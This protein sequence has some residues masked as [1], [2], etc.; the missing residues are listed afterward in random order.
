MSIGNERARIEVSNDVSEYGG[1]TVECESNESEEIEDEGLVN[2]LDAG[3]V[4]KRTD[5]VSRG[6]VL[7]IRFIF[8]EKIVDGNDCVCRDEGFCG[9]RTGSGCGTTTPETF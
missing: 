3:D 7:L 4:V 9:T 1:C 6:E 2:V 5:D 8:F